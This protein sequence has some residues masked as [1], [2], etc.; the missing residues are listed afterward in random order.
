MTTLIE[1][2]K[3]ITY[4]TTEIHPYYKSINH[5]II[6][7]F[8]DLEFT[9]EIYNPSGQK[10]NVRALQ[11][12]N[13]IETPTLSLIKQWVINLIGGYGGLKYKVSQCWGAKYNKGDYTISHDH[14]GYAFAFVY[15]VRSPKGSSPLVFTTSRKR[16]KP[17]EG[18]LV[19][20]HGNLLH[21]V[22]KNKCVD[23]IVVAGNVL[24]FL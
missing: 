21:E 23:R 8:K 9:T 24:S 18:K 12:Y 17:M 16:I 1:Y 7:E 15:F 5:K 20:F 6:E 11:T 3:E 19:L 14:F 22:P 4:V 10:T 13:D 2:V